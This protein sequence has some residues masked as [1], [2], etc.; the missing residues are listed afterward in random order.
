MEVS[1]GERRGLAVTHRQLVTLQ[2]HQRRSQGDSAPITPE[3]K[4]AKIRLPGQI[5]GVGIPSVKLSRTLLEPGSHL[6]SWH[7]VASEKAAGAV[8]SGRAGEDT[9]WA[10]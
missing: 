9:D 8:L 7:L 2:F 4:G 6:C 5:L 1:M 10:H 3:A